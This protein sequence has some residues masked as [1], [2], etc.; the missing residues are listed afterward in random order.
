M[1][2]PLEREL[3]ELLKSA[4]RIAD[5]VRLGAEVTADALDLAERTLDVVLPLTTRVCLG[6]VVETRGENQV[7]Q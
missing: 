2:T 7:R 6:N 3:H 1:I 4:L 5:K